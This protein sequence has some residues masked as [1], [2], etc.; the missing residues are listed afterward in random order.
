[1]GRKPHVCNK[2]KKGYTMKQLLLMVTLLTSLNV[3]ADYRE[4]YLSEKEVRVMMESDQR[5]CVVDFTTSGKGYLGINKTIFNSLND[6][7][8]WTH[9]DVCEVEISVYEIEGDH[10]RVIDNLYTDNLMI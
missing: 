5:V 7:M 8:I 3:H 4:T 1:M 2:T 9:D 6:E 10:G